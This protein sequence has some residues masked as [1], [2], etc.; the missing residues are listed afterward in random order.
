MHRFHP[1]AL[2]MVDRAITITSVGRHRRR[3]H[4]RRHHRRRRCHC[5]VRGT[6]SAVAWSP[7]SQPQAV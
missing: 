6:I 3:H 5:G 7:L 1:A 4:R 2:G